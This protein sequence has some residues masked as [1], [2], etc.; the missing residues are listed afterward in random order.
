MV[1]TLNIQHLESLTDV[2]RQITGVAQHETVPDEVVRRAEQVQLVD[3]A[4]RRCAAVWR[5]ATSTPRRRS[6]RRCRA[7]S[8]RGT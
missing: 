4:P 7:T 8:G 6:T 1:S 5:T 2:V 3:M